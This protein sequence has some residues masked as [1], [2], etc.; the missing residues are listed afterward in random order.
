MKFYEVAGCGWAGESY[1]FTSKASAERCIKL[2]LETYGMEPELVEHNV[3]ASRAEIALLIGLG[4]EAAG[5]HP[6]GLLLVDA[7]DFNVGKG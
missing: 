3:N 2:D 7:P 1:F 6:T 5:G 4:I